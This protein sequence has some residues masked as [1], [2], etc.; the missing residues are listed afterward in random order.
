MFEPL[1]ILGCLRFPGCVLRTYPGYGN[2]VAIEESG[3]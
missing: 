1:R 2:L 3:A